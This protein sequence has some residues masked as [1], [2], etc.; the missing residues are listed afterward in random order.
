MPSFD[1]NGKRIRKGDKV[2]RAARG[3]DVIPTKRR[4]SLPPEVVLAVGR[5]KQFAGYVAIGVHGFR[6]WER[7]SNFERL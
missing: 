1:I 5:G 2:R 7:G 4:T 6:T 3:S